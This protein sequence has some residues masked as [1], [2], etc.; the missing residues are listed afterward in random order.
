M[1]R[2][3]KSIGC[4]ISALMIG[5]FLCGA[6]LTVFGQPK[7]EVFKD[8][9]TAVEDYRAIF[10]KPDKYGDSTLFVGTKKG[11][12]M[13]SRIQISA[14]PFNPVF[15]P[16]SFVQPTNGLIKDI[17]FS[18][19]NG[20]L[21]KTDGIYM[22]EG[23]SASWKPL[24]SIKD[25]PKREGATAELW[26][27]SFTDNLRACIVG[28][29]F[30]DNSDDIDK[31]LLLCTNNINDKKQWEEPKKPK[32][33]K[34]EQLQ[35]TNIYFDKNTKRGWAVGTNGVEGIIWYSENRGESWEEI[36]AISSEPLLGVFAI[37]EKGVAVGLSGMV[38]G[39]G[40][41]NT[42]ISTTVIPTKPN[43][44]TK[45]EE[46]DT[47]EIK[48]TSVSLMPKIGE[49]IQ[50]KV[51]PKVTGIVKEVKKSGM[52]IIKE[53]E[54]DSNSDNV[55]EWIKK[56]F[57]NKDINPKDVVVIKKKGKDNDSNTITVKNDT[58]DDWKKIGVP[59]KNPAPILRSVK[60]DNE[61]NGFIIGDNGTILFMKSG[62]TMWKSLPNAQLVGIDLYSIVIDGNYALIAGTKGT[63]VRIE[64]NPVKK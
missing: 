12:V 26:G 44:N 17:Y 27:I 61:G 55:K 54:V 29:Y 47:V 8:K 1:K 15:R 41:G 64:I 51:I 37:W 39:K 57:E 7:I 52:L 50:D 25:L 56:R 53:I 5:L 16:L 46:G 11:S 21:V 35:L 62:E 4:K 36:K 32:E 3:E 48:N 6:I 42:T 30:K 40:F 22:I 34:T 59:L 24:V 58:S 31:E 18:S 14:T 13:L 9:K 43:P 2:Q 19:E 63:I 45:A 20:Y 49:I 38:F 10:V 60:F 23:N 33:V 28:T